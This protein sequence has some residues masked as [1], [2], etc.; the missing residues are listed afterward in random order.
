MFVKGFILTEVGKTTDSSQAGN[1]PEEWFKLAEWIP[2]HGSQEP[3]EEFWRTLVADRGKDGRNPPSYYSRACKESVFKGGLVSGSVS[4]SDLINNERNSII[5]QFCRR[6]QAVIWNRQLIRTESGHL[7]IT[8]K[9]VKRGDAVCILYGCSVPVI[10]RRHEKSED[11][12]QDEAEEDKYFSKLEK[13]CGNEM[14]LRRMIRNLKLKKMW[15]ERPDSVTEEQKKTQKWKFGKDEVKRDLERYK[16]ALLKGKK[17]ERKVLETQERPTTV[18]KEDR[19]PIE[20]PWC[21]Y[22]FLGECY[23]HG[24][25]DG[26]GKHPFSGPSPIYMFGNWLSIST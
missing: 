15:K 20:E 12:I 8:R 1:I 5:T 19:Q 7:G 16:M 17:I 4:T 23:I 11:V 22:E 26:E 18:S 3:S 14:L 2:T 6:V 25:M 24:M 10:L 9:G 13:Y 21:Y